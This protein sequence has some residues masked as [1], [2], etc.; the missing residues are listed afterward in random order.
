MMIGETVRVAFSSIRDHK[1][2]ALLTMLGII[3]GVA[4]VIAVVAIG[5]G[6]QRKIEARIQALGANLL[7]INPGQSFMMGR[8]SDIRVS[9][10]V[11]DAEA[12][13]QD[14]HLLTA[15]EPEMNRSL[16]VK[17]GNKNLNVNILGATPNFAQVRNFEVPFG[18]M[19]TEGDDG[20]RQRFA[21]L[22][23]SV[24]TMLDAN[25]AAL[26]HQTIQIRGQPFEVIGV[27]NAK[28][29]TGMGGN[30]DEQIVIPLSTARYRIFGTDRLRGIA[31]LVRD[32]ITLD[33]GMLDIE[34][35]L[36]R[37][38][39][40]RPGGDNDFQIRNQQDILSTQQDTANTFKVLLGSIAGVSLLVGGIG[41]MN[42]MLVSVTERTRE[43]G[44]RKALG[45]TRMTVMQQFLIE[46][47]VLCL[48]GGVLGIFTGG[49]AAW[50]LKKLAG[51]DTII[52][53]LSVMVAFAFSAI[54]GLAFGLWPAWRAATLNTIDA[55]RYE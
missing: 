14:A 26:I 4:A 46:A 54:V 5:T 10:T 31:V 37:E 33:Q 6:A 32:G 39:K 12:L 13:A 3:I 21:V 15:V 28:G 45:A 36:R 48:M 41:I 29:S 51:F 16:Q 25:P 52:S 44:V 23:A 19:F 49:G 2:R 50:L 24:P 27:L 53:P 1:L 40:I 34:R 20:S 18:R 30:Q 17:Y 9:L 8:A 7:T 35:V 47:L 42:I 38:H 22:G 55:L 43:I 11:K